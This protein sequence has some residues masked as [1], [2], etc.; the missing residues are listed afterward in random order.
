M[1][2]PREAPRNCGNSSGP[3]RFNL[4]YSEGVVTQPTAVSYPDVSFLGHASEGA[5]Q[6]A[7]HS[8]TATNSGF[9]EN[10]PS[11]TPPAGSDLWR[12]NPLL[13]P[14]PQVMCDWLSGVHVFRQERE[15][16][17]SGRVMKITPDGEIEW[18]S[19]SW[20]SVE[21]ASS[22][23]SLR[24][25]SDGKRLW[26]SGNVGRFQER[27]NVRGLTVPEC[28]RKL[29]A[30]L[31]QHDVRLWDAEF[32][33]TFTMPRR[34][35]S[36]ERETAGV[37]ASRR[38][39]F[40]SRVDLAANFRVSC[41]S[42]ICHMLGSRVI[43]RHVPIMG[44]YGPTWGYGKR[45]NWWKGKVYDKTAEQ[46]GK[47]RSAGGE[48]VARF[49]VQLGA[50]FLRR[51]GLD[52]CEQWIWSGESDDRASGVDRMGQVIWAEFG[53][54]V[55]RELVPERL[56][57]EEMPFKLRL[58]AGAWKDGNDLRLALGKS[59]FYARRKELLAFGIDIGLPCNVQ[60]LKPTVQSVQV[61][62]LPA[63]RYG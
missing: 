7:V 28:V 43:G 4:T 41:F 23:T 26:F 46:E 17:E 36:P 54:Q 45:S 50:E 63:L 32:G 55:F 2:P 62:F 35:E 14:L 60:A 59:Q 3:G 39:T 51:R 27:D 34:P 22:D 20:A 38:G 48:T 9:P 15:P 18:Q 57:G 12:S 24:V 61:E 6:V 25:K 13:N 29:R 37:E 42:D 30:I 47:R 31:A 58:L 33:R 11:G 49:E 44:R 53:G 19:A 5:G 10:P 21:C 52:R 16:L 8:T 56:W 40:L 1:V